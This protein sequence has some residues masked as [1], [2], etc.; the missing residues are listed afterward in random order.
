MLHRG[1]RP[2]AHLSGRRDNKPTDAQA[3]VAVVASLLRQL[4]AVL[5]T[6]TPWDPTVTAGL[7][8]LGRGNRPPETPRPKP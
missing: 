1:H 8:L 7:T 3:R 5:I 4:H 6:A 2:H